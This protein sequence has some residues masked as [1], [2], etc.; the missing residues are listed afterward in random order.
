MNSP[1]QGIRVP[2][3][4]FAFFIL[5]SVCVA[6]AQVH[7]IPTAKELTALVRDGSAIS[8]AAYGLANM[9]AIE[10]V[11]IMREKFSALIIRDK[12]NEE[13]PSDDL[14]DKLALASALVRLGAR[15][16]QF[17]KLLL[18]QGAAAADS[19]APWPLVFDSKGKVI[20]GQ[21]SP[22]LVKWAESRKFHPGSVTG[23]QTYGVQL[24]L[25]PLTRIVEPRALPILRRAL[26]S[27]NYYV[28]YLAAEGL[29]ALGDK[30]SIPSILDNWKKMPP[31]LA[32]FAAN[33]LVYFDD[34]R[35]RAESEKLIK[36]KSMLERMR[37]QFKNQGGKA[38]FKQGQD[39]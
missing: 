12:N 29:A 16:D 1:Q 7:P 25:M 6:S 4:G 5:I 17:I 14:L 18:E 34:P 36:D 3:A 8:S 39:F 28:Q 10:A 11:P 23:N 27:Q 15:D 19:D 13:M 20:K 2:T 30:E 38:V 9:G 26:K 35:T 21:M 22:A 37:A 33:I 24:R 32:E 31:E